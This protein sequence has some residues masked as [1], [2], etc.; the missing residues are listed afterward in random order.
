[1]ITLAAI[2][3]KP[4]VSLKITYGQI[5]AVWNFETYLKRKKKKIIR[6]WTTIKFKKLFTR[7]GN[8]ISYMNYRSSSPNLC[9]APYLGAL[10]RKKIISLVPW[11]QLTCE[12]FVKYASKINQDNTKGFLLK[13]IQSKKNEPNYLV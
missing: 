2:I 10:S 4:Q 11:A 3:Q 1:M 5:R 6:I 7:Y 13:A 12:C 8:K 9:T